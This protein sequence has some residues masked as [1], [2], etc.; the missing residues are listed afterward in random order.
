MVQLPKNVH[1]MLFEM[2]EFMPHNLLF[3]PGHGSPTPTMTTQ[4]SQIPY[5]NSD[6]VM[7]LKQSSN[8]PWELFCCLNE[9]GH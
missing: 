6:V 4:R 9:D 5:G 7:Q 1:S 8:G 2:T 3:F